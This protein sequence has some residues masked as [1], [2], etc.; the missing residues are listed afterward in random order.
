MSHNAKKTRKHKQNKNVCTSKEN[1]NVCSIVN[2]EE[3][4]VGLAPFSSAFESWGDGQR[5]GYVPLQAPDVFWFAS[6]PA[7]EQTGPDGMA[8]SIIDEA[9]KQHLLRLFE[10]WSGQAQDG[11]QI[12]NLQRLILSSPASSILRTPIRKVPDVEKFPWQGNRGRVI[13]LGDSAH[14]VAP[15]LAQG[16]GL[17]IEDALV[18]ATNLSRVVRGEASLE[19]AARYY[20]LARKP[21]AKTVQSMADLVATVGHIRGPLALARN[22][23]MLASHKLAPT[24]QSLIFERAVSMSLGGDSNN[25]YW[26]PPVPKGTVDAEALT[27]ALER[28]CLLGRV[29]GATFSELPSHVRKFRA[30]SEGEGV[31]IVSVE[32]GK[33]L[34]TRLV[35]G[36]PPDMSEQPFFA[37]VSE[38]VGGQLWTRKF[39][40]GPGATVYSTT[41]TVERSSGQMALSEGVGGL[42]DKWVRFRYSVHVKSYRTRPTYVSYASK[43]LWFFGIPL[44]SLLSARS[45]WAEEINENGWNFDGEIK[46]PFFGRLMHYFGNFQLPGSS[47]PPKEGITK[48]R[49]RVVIA[50][51]TG[52]LGSA[53]CHRFVKAGWEVVVLSRSGKSPSP[54]CK[55]VR[56]DGRSGEGWEHLV[57][58]STV[59]VNLCGE[60]PGAKRWD[61]TFKNKIVDSRLQSIHAMRTVIQAKKPRT[62]LQASAV[63]IYGNRGDEKLGDEAKLDATGK[64][65][66][67]CT[68]Q[69]EA[70]ATKAV[71]GSGC[72]VK[73]LRLGI[74]LSHEGGL[75]PALELA[76]ICGATRLGDGK[77]YLPWIHIHD[78][79]EAIV[80]LS[81]PENNNQ[82]GSFNICAPNPVTYSE[83]FR[84]SAQVNSRL[85]MVPVP[86]WLLERAIGE[87]AVII[88]DSQR[89]LPERLLKDTGFEFTF[90]NLDEALSNMT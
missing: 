34:I 17:A 88:F 16:A 67:E 37:R 59:L 39:G 7:A 55:A 32:R 64:F 11:A 74:V 82:S 25:L 71:E 3:H 26:S 58:S 86:R 51:G 12:V 36:L 46:L 31:G 35:P 6:I 61:T 29:L 27:R 21:R 44:P 4:S 80:Q 53:V 48:P 42:F 66:E 50:G 38:A 52:L 78:A 87:S 69:I 76:S 84:T 65:R 83:F 2:V 5:F 75:L 56:W 15:N 10:G 14:A 72:S 33:S 20:E 24:V 85:S 73:L 45:H 19:A 60:N 43:G 28:S 9:T 63:G 23:F 1:K 68:R 49:G 57:D 77:Q 62:F 54:A 22:Y 90:P 81:A 8:T 41:H 13:L 89:V 47:P 70:T 30:A 40:E 79:A 18:L